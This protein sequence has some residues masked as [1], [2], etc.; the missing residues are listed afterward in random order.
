MIDCVYLIGV[1]RRTQGHCT[2]W[3][4]HTQGLSSHYFLDWVIDVYP[5]NVKDFL[6]S[7]W[8]NEWLMFICTC[9]G[10]FSLFWMIDWLILSVTYTGTFFSPFWL[11][12]CLIFTAV[13][14]LAFFSPIFIEWVVD[15]FSYIKEFFFSIFWLKNIFTPSFTGDYITYY[16][17]RQNPK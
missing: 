3:T 13:Q 7:F 14:V 15:A 8:M 6:L 12:E 16:Y 10:T 2:Y 4:L 11:N 5:N 17:E 1:L 9:K